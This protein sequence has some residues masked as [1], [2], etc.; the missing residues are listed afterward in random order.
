MCNLSGRPLSATPRTALSAGGEYFQPL[1]LGN[2]SGEVF[3]RSDLTYRTRTY[4]DPSDSKYTLISG[5]TLVNAVLG[6]RS[7]AHWEAS[8][9][10]RNLLNRDYLQNLTV[11]A[12]N[13]GLIVGTP[14][15]P[16]FVGGTLRIMF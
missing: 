6:F 13:S 15:D 1:N 2:L 11:Q 9:W 12:G 4:G 7:T 16:R 5:Y 3:L 14:S 10:V 8:V